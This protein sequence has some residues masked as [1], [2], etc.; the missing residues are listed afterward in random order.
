MRDFDPPDIR[1]IVLDNWYNRSLIQDGLP[2]GLADDK[3]SAD[4][5][6]SHVDTNNLFFTTGYHGYCLGDWYRHYKFEYNLP[7]SV[8]LDQ[9][10]PRL[11][12]LLPLF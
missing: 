7:A 6:I 9:S 8:G 2:A 4:A 3:S 5:D 11:P 10:L 1:A 12:H